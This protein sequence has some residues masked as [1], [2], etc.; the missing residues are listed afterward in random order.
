MEK[1]ARVVFYTRLFPLVSSILFERLATCDGAFHLYQREI[2][3]RLV[4]DGNDV[5][6]RKQCFFSEKQVLELLQRIA[7][8]TLQFGAIF[9]AHGVLDTAYRGA[10]H[11]RDFDR[12]EVIRDFQV[13][14]PM[15]YV[16]I[17]VDMSDD[18]PRKDIC[19]C[20]TDKDICDAC[21]HA[22]M[23][24]AQAALECMLDYMGFKGSYF[25]VFSGRRGFHLWLVHPRV[26][27]WTKIQRHVFAETISKPQPEHPMTRQVVAILETYS[28]FPLALWPRIDIAITRDCTHLVGVPLTCHQATGYWRGPMATPVSSKNR[29]IPSQDRVPGHLVRDYHMQVGERVIREALNKTN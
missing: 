10:S 2:A 8:A 15:G 5:H 7:P 13:S 21:W 20:A 4:I 16:V 14:S 29:F 17:D 22:F 27:R 23:D 28:S 12:F 3:P 19:L 25:K 26:V 9:P 6:M 18:C 24:P 11:L 1:K